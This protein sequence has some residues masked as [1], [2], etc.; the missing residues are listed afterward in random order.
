LC[1]KSL[2]ILFF[3]YDSCSLDVVDFHIV[4][5]L[6]RLVV[7]DLQ[8]KGAQLCNP[9]HLVFAIPAYNCLLFKVNYLKRVVHRTKDIVVGLIRQH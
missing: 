1:S 6:H 7:N 8:V 5:I 9:D 4:V 3:N 2:A